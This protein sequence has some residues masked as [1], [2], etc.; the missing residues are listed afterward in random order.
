MAGVD[1]EQ[2]AGVE[3][4]VRPPELAAPRLLDPAW[5]PILHG[6]T[7]SASNRARFLPRPRSARHEIRPN[8]PTAVNEL[9]REGHAQAIKSPGFQGF[10]MRLRGVEP[11]RT[12]RS[13]RPSTLRVYQ[14]RHRRP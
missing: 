11:P 1:V 9:G 4:S 14:F 6:Q 13:T 8:R 7:V 3:G 2:L 10:P 5:V 12:L